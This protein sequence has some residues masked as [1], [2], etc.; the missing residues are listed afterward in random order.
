M[1]IKAIKTAAP[2]Q[3]RQWQYR[4]HLSSSKY[5]ARI[6]PKSPRVHREHPWLP[7][8]IS[9]NNRVVRWRQCQSYRSVVDWAKVIRRSNYRKVARRA[10][11]SKRKLKMK[12]FSRIV[13]RRTGSLVCP[14]CFSTDSSQWQGQDS[15]S[16]TIWYQFWQRVSPKSSNSLQRFTN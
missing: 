5:L 14:L 16:Q 4:T 10:T 3:D 6:L 2:Q 9:S 7:N 11:M 1:K 13:A 12:C 8:N 15:P